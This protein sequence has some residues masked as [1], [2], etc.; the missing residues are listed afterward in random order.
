MTKTTNVFNYVL[1]DEALTQ[2]LAEKSAH[3]FSDFC[4]HS[5]Q[6]LKLYFSGEIGA[7]KTTFIRYFLRALNITDP[8][9]SP[10]Y[11]LIERY[12]THHLSVLHADLYRLNHPQEIYDLDLFDD[13]S[14]I[15]LIEW[16]E[17]GQGILDSADIDLHLFILNA[18]HHL[19]MSI[20]NALLNE[21]W[22]KN[23]EI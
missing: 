21:I 14:N 20:N 5:H 1:K 12:S 19:N 16:P 7:G 22:Q 23:P 13:N 17:K 10:T 18:T 9:K 8:I 3:I 15:F 11:T 6:T 2:A 4:L